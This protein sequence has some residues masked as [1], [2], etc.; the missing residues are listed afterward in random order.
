[1]IISNSSPL[2]LLAKINRLD[3]MKKLYKKI[4]IPMGVYKEVVVKG[5]EEGYGD[6]FLIENHVGEFIFIEKLDPEHMKESEKL[7]NVLGSGESE[8]IALALQKKAET[9][10]IDNLEPRKTAELK[11]IKCRSTPGVLLEALKNKVISH[12][13]YKES[14]KKLSEFAWLD[15][16]IVAYFLDQS[17]KMEYGE[18]K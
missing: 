6:A 5:K 2:I 9:L 16:A 12:K 13:E 15:G 14:I 18:K 4:Y 10:I 11:G 3:L 1:M 17:Y 7:N 8:A